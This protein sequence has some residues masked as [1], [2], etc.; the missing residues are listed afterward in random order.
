MDIILASASPRRAQLLKQ[1][2][3]DFTVAASDIDET[4]IINESAVDYVQRMASQKALVGQANSPSNC[5]IIGADTVVC[6]NQRVL[7][8]PQDEAEACASLMALSGRIHSVYT[9][10]NVLYQGRSLQ[11]MSATEVVFRQINEAEARAYWASGEP[12][13]KAG[14]YAIQGLG[15]GFVSSIQGSYSGVVGLPLYEL[16]QLLAELDI[17]PLSHIQQ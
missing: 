4:Q 8:K 11:E 12:L 16:M 5:V 1:I 6:L 13:D 9:A 7:S 17:Q 3:L 15:A 2:Q 14:G 10:L